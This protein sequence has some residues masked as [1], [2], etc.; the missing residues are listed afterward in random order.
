M[1]AVRI[2]LAFCTPI[3]FVR[4]ANG[5]YVPER[6]TIDWHRRRMAISLPTNFNVIDLHCDG[7]EVGDARNAAVL[8]ALEHPRKPEFIF[9]LD[10]DVLPEFDAVTKLIFRA[11][12][13]PD[14]DIFAGVYVAKYMNPG[15]PLI[16]KGDGQGPFWDYAMGDLI[17][18]GVTGVHM[19]C[20]LIRMSAFEKVPATL[21]EP[22][23]KTVNE[24]RIEDGVL[25]SVRGTEDLYFCNK[26][27]QAGCKILVD[28]SVMCGHIDHATG[29]IYGLTRDSNPIRR[30]HWLPGTGEPGSQQ[31]SDGEH[32][33]LALDLGAGDMRREWPGYRVYTTDLRANVG[34]DYVQ[35][36]RCLNLP[37]NHFDLVACAPP[38]Q[39]VLTPRGWHPIET[40][41][42]GDI[43]LGRTGWVRVLNNFSRPFSGSVF[44]IEAAECRLEV[45][46]NHPIATPLQW[47]KADQ[48]RETEKVFAV[49]SEVQ[50]AKFVD[51]SHIASIITRASSFTPIDASPVA[52]KDSLATESGDELGLPTFPSQIRQTAPQ[53]N[54]SDLKTRMNGNSPRL[55]APASNRL[56]GSETVS[57]SEFGQNLTKGSQDVEIAVGDLDN[58]RDDR[59]FVDLDRNVAL[60]VDDPGEVSPIGVLCLV[61]HV[62]KVSELHHV[63]E[64][65]NLETQDGTFFLEGLLTHNSSHHLEHIPRWEQEQ[66]WA[67]IFRVTKR[68]GQIEHVV[69]DLTWAAAKIHDG[70]VDEHVMNVLYGAQEAHGYER[71]LNLHYF[72]YTPELAK[73]LAERAGFVDVETRNWRQDE[74]LGYNLIITGRKPAAAEI[75]TEDLSCPTPAQPECPS[76]PSTAC[77]SK[78]R[79][80]SK[81][82]KKRPAG[83]KP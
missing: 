28:T 7:M 57:D 22:W 2:G 44:R 23:F 10:Y 52:V 46:G 59:S 54:L 79:S 64:V 34:A 42:T 20:T 80:C 56:H 8:R 51:R 61:A 82:S 39:R 77:P 66:A 62:D 81:R 69:P 11:R 65:Y 40:I 30:A 4:A 17:T 53:E 73:E 15:E 76:D 32:E 48:F 37:D 55:L 1:H 12:H 71:T 27:V 14:Y 18:E 25:H 24:K 26:A 60:T 16:Y 9:F 21:E 41:V 49:P 68:G 19:G 36:T 31:A 13:F 33:K 6:I 74:T 58:G 70:H 78:R 5:Q 47:L 3:P 72:G 45:T 75:S 38:G 67:E 50:P 43:V 83:K 29:Q 35:D 63:G